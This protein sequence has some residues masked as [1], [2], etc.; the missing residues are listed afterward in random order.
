MLVRLPFNRIYKKTILKLLPLAGGRRQAHYEN[1]DREH[2]PR[3]AKKGQA[4]E[5][6][7]R[8]HASFVER[9]ALN[10]PTFL[11]CSFQAPLSVKNKI[12]KF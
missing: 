4:L 9:R 3:N 6:Q 8:H 7:P 2:E 10:Q 5:K 1:E 11:V 12:K